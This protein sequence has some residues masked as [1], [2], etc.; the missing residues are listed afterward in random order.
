MNAR[1]DPRLTT[2]GLT[3]TVPTLIELWAAHTPADNP[4]PATCPACGHTYAPD[5]PL[6][7]TAATVRPLLRRRR[8]EVAPAAFG[9]LTVNQHEDLFGKRLSTQVPASRDHQPDK[10]G[11]ISAPLFPIASAPT[12]GA[13]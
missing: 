3:I 8:N 4:A 10:P 9:R 6:C 12:G 2:A 13:R 5:A 11:Y 1:L 7:P